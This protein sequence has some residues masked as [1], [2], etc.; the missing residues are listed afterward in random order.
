MM[1]HFEED[2]PCITVTLSYLVHTYFIA[3]MF[4]NRYKKVVIEPKLRK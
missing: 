2:E 4:L 3:R 1:A